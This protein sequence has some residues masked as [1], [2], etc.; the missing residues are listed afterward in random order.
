MNGSWHTKQK[1]VYCI[2]VGTRGVGGGA[3]APQY[4]RKGGR[5]PLCFPAQY[6][7]NLGFLNIFQ[8]RL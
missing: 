7:H 8:A 5:A 3:V 4:S 1:I 2:G 6:C